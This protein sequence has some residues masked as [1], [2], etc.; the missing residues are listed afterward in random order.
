MNSTDTSGKPDMNALLGIIRDLVGEIHP[1]WKNL[2]FLPDTHLERELGLDSM[3]RAELHGRIEQALGVSLPE[4]AA[5]RA[6][7]AGDIMNALVNPSVADDGD[8]IPAGSAADLLM[9]D[10]GE[11]NDSATESGRCTAG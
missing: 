5:V 4:N 3:A 6:A 9:G 10:F 2:H 1:H 7:T 8:D 11:R